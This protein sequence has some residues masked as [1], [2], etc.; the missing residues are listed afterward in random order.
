MMTRVNPFFSWL[1]L[2][3]AV[4]A[5]FAAPVELKH[6]MYVCANLSGQ[7]QVMGGRVAVPSG[8][9]RSHDRQTFEHIGPTHIRLFS[10]ARD[11]REVNT[12]WV[13]ALDGVL[14]SRDLGATWRTMTDWRMTEPHVVA[15]DPNAPDSIYAGLPD[16]IAVSND[17]GQRWRRMNDGIR[18]SFTHGLA[19]DRTTA[20][21][22]LAG[23]ELGIYLTEDGARTWRLVQPTTKVTYDIRQSPAEPRAFLAV[24]SSDGAFWSDDSGRTWRAVAGVPKTHT[25]HNCA[26]DPSDAHRIAIG[27][28]GCGVLVSEDGG[29]TWQDR[30]AGLP[31]REIWRVSTDPDF[32]GRLYAAP[33]LAPLHVS[34]DLG[35]TWRP[36]VFEKAIVYDI[37]F[38]ARS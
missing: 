32:P 34:D 10:V 21:R 36:L 28:W 26:F 35:R 9:Q 23:T 12:L 33:N 20:G 4:S 25:L 1:A 6:D 11:P 27:G 37:V 5:S 15:I 13:A 19:V 7:G 18:R 14:R 16:G 29:K 17:A 8:L 30:G 31:N 2:A 24:T 3:T 38:V 22:V